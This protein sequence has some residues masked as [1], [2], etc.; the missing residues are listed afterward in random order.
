[1][2]AAAN[3]ATAAAKAAASA[4]GTAAVADPGGA[5][6]LLDALSRQLGL[7]FEQKKR[8]MQ[9]LVLDHIEETPTEN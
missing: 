1:M 7:K 5:I 6:S 4:D 8:P 3:A 9:V 2:R